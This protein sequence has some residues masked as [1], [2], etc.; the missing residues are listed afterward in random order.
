MLRLN[1]ASARIVADWLAAA[2]AAASSTAAVDNVPLPEFAPRP[3]RL[4]LGAR[5]VPHSAALSVEERKFA[6]KLKAKPT[7]AGSPAAAK[8]AAAAAPRDESESDEEEGRSS[9]VRK[10]KWTQGASATAA[11]ARKTAAKR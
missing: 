10:R 5:Y 3:E 6:A 1:N 2:P 4:G 11:P 7:P 8:A 9:S